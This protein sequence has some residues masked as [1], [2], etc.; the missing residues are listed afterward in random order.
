MYSCWH[1]LAHMLMTICVRQTF[2]LGCPAQRG[3][4]SDGRESHESALF[5]IRLDMLVD[6]CLLFIVLFVM[7]MTVLGKHVLICL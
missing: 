5:F 4:H 3:N 6:S 1:W 7:E 2:D